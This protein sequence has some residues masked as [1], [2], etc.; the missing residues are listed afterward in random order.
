MLKDGEKLS[1][2]R[3]ATAAD[4]LNLFLD[5]FTEAKFVL[6][7]MGVWEYLYGVSSRREGLR[8]FSLIRSRFER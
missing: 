5:R 8:L 3:L 7:S 1:N 6:E 2:E 4:A